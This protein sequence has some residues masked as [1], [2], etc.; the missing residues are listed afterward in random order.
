MAAA[1]SGGL[2]GVMA[3]RTALSTVGQEGHGLSYRGYSIDDLAEHAGFEEV[4]WLL[5]RGELPT[6]SELESYQQRLLGL[7]E[8]PEALK[9]VLEQLPSTT[10]PMD[11]LRTGCSALGCLEPE[12][13]SRTGLDIADRL[14]AAFPSMLLYWHQFHEAGKQIDLQTDDPTLSGHFLRLMNGRRA[15][16][17]E[18]RAMGASLILY[19]EHEYNAS[20]FAARVATSTLSDFYS[21]ITAAIGTLR[22]SLHGGANEAAFDLI[23]RFDSLDA[24]EQGI[25]E[26]LAS[27]EKIMGFGHR[28]YTDCDPRSE[29]MQPWARRLSKHHEAGDLYA[30]SER[31]DQVMRREKNVFPNLAFYSA[32]AYHFLEIPTAFF[33]PVFVFARTAGWSA[34]ILEQRSENRLIRPNAEYVGPDSRPFVQSRDRE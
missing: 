25:Q 6:R 18:L 12:G 21:A 5:L 26:M 2:A 9:R 30:I 32:S 10:H 11:V 4:A 13:D 14:L 34:H 15:N 19:A 8:I 1:V 27:K 17:P 3:G 29:I 23:T 16:T 33:T 7:R 20:A 31:I 28:V 24:A 22:G